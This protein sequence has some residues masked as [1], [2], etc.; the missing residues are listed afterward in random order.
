MP[1]FALSTVWQELIQL[2]PSWIQG[3]IIV[4]DRITQLYSA[5]QLKPT[6]YF[7]VAAKVAQSWLIEIL[8]FSKALELLYMKSWAE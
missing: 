3:E 5:P 2:S 1:F 7:V 4:L 6:H 8:P